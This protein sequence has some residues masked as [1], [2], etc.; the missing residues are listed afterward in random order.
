MRHWSQSSRDAKW[1]E[2]GEG[3]ELAGERQK[4]NIRRRGINEC[5]EAKNREE[6]QN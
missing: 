3:H 1:V 6:R 5:Y 2:E 4:M